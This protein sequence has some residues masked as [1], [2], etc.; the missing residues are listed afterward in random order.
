[1]ELPFSFNIYCSHPTHARKGHFACFEEFSIVLNVLRS[2][3]R[4]TEKRW[5]CSGRNAG[6]WNV[7]V[8]VSPLLLQCGQSYPEIQY[9]SLS[10][11]LWQLQ[12]MSV[13]AVWLALTKINSSR[14]HLTEISAALIGN[15]KRTHTHGQSHSSLENACFRTFQLDHYGPTDRRAKLFKELRVRN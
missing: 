13:V 1:M 12:S 4:N 15:A 2:K 3:N 10:A 14:N 7:K 9:R 8:K 6:G 11:T 5:I